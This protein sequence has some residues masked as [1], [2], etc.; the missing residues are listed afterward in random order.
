LK[1]WLLT[2]PEWSHADYNG[3]DSM[4]VA[5]ETEED[6]RN[7]HPYGTWVVQYRGGVEEHDWLDKP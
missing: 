4:V 2:R 7:T 6:A 5:A 3:F 1:L